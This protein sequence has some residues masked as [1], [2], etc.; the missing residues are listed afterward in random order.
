MSVISS[1]MLND[2][3]GAMNRSAYYG[4]SGSEPPKDPKER[5]KERIKNLKSKKSKKEIKK[6]KKFYY[7]QKETQNLITK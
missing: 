4:S 5:D 7:F 2:S 1:K 6:K 3:I